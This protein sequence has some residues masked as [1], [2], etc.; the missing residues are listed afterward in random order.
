MKM[1]TSCNDSGKLVPYSAFTA[2][3][4]ALPAFYWD[5]Y[6]SEQRIKEL[7]KELCK[8]ADYA[9]EL[10]VHI[11]LN[12]D[13][14]TKLQNE[15]QNLKDGGLLDYYEKQIYQWIQDNMR[16]I[17]AAACKQV[18]FGL[19][20]DGYFVAYVPDSWKEITF[21]T[22]A[23]FGRSDYGRLILRFDAEGNAINNT[24]AYS[25]S[26][27]QP[28]KQLIADLEVNAKRTDSTFD[29]LFTNLDKEVAAPQ[30]NQQQTSKSLVKAGDNV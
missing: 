26:Q 3:T 4:P 9:N 24:Y 29:T 16:D 17:M 27:T 23:V 20:D 14:I 30:G 5:V 2:A 8:L 25:L 15:L 13:D 28:L 18:Y 7:C 10:G 6:S 21:D 22:G 1:N 19:N 12:K 11:N